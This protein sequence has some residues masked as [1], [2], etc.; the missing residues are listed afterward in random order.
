MRVLSTYHVIC[1]DEVAYT[2][3]DKVV[4]LREINIIFLIHKHCIN[5]IG[6]HIGPTDT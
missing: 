1:D 2:A 5:Q 4:H 6:A 3:S